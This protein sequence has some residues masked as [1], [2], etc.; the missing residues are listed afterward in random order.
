MAEAFFV[1]YFYFCHFIAEEVVIFAISY[2]KDLFQ[3]LYLAAGN[4]SKPRPDD[5][6]AIARALEEKFNQ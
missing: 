4:A 6:K 3:I 2:G 1:H 5:A